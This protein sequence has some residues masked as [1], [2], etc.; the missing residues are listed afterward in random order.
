MSE[1]TIVGYCR[2][3]GKALAESEAQRSQGAMYCKQHVPAANGFNGSP[4]T[5]PPPPPGPAS[6]NA[7][8]PGVAF[9]LGLIPGVGAIYNGQYAKGLVHVAVIGLA[10]SALSSDAVTGYEPLVA[11]LM[12]AFW[13]YMPFEAYHTAQRR[14]A[15]LPVEGQLGTGG[16]SRLPVTPILLIALGTIL[17]LN[18][19][20]LLDLRR[21]LRFW[22]ALLIGAGLYMLLNRFSPPADSGKS[23]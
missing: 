21:T 3:C 20:G 8:S 2:A 14:L 15:G 17:L 7:I 1:A 4:Y 12:V 23:D 10:I 22:P 6:S 11:L 5:A 16:P 18:N 9:V 19:L 13:A